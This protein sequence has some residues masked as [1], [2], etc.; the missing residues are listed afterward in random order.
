MSKGLFITFEGP[1]GA[2]KTTQIERLTAHISKRGLPLTVTREPGGTAIGEKIRALLLDP[3]HCEMD[4]VAEALLYAASR[5]QHV[6]E[7][8]APALLDGRVVVCDRFIDSSLAYQGFGRKLGEKLI[9]ELNAP[10][11]CGVMPDLTLCVLAK[12]DTS[13]RRLAQKEGGPDRLESENRDFFTRVYEG[14][15]ALCREYPERMLLLDADRDIDD[16]AAIIR[17]RTDLALGGRLEL[18]NKPV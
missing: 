2:G 13:L 18:R 1:D 15:R 10:A 8:I 16:I 4:P 14:Y 3:D 7:I 17:E 6:R 11:L 12:P 5:A 9:W